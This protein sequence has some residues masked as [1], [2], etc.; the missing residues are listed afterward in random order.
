MHWN[1]SVETKSFVK[2]KIS[3]WSFI[4]FV[5]KFSCKC[6]LILHAQKLKDCRWVKTEIK[7]KLKLFFVSYWFSPFTGGLLWFHTIFHTTY[8]LISYSYSYSYHVSSSFSSSPDD[9]YDV[10]IFLSCYALLYY[11]YHYCY[12]PYYFCFI[13]Y[14]LLSCH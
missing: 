6:I 8:L 3:F 12:I 5:W 11:Y 9:Y 1:Y 7:K 10:I 4:S 2:L 14:C 13:D